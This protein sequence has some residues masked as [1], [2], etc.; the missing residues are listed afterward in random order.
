MSAATKWF[1]VDRAGLA[2][3]ARRRGVPFIVTEPIQNAW[4]EATRIVDVRISPVAN[5]P[6]VDLVVGDDSPDGFRDLR[7][8]YTLFAESYKLDDPEKRGRFNIGEKLLLAVADEARIESTT[9]TVEFGRDGR[10]TLRYRTSAGSILSA[11]LRMTRAELDEALSILHTLIPPDGVATSINGVRLPSRTPI[12]TGFKRTLPTEIRG[13]EGGFRQT[14]RQ[15]TVKIYR[16]LEGE[17]PSLYEMGIPVDAI[18]CPWHVDVGQK[19]PLSVDRSSVRSSY[20]AEIERIAAELMADEMSDDDAREGWVSS[21]LD[22]MED[23]D[24][25]REILRKR[26][27]KAVIFDPSAPQSNKL[28]LDAGYKVIHGSE[29]SRGAWETLRRAEAFEP[30]GRVFDTGQIG[31]SPDGV[32][33]VPETEWTPAMSRAYDYAT[34]FVRHAIGRTLDVVFYDDR[35]LPFS[36]VCGGGRIGINLANG[37]RR[38]IETADQEPLDALLIHET[39]HVRGGSDHLTERFY[40]EC[41]RIGARMRTFEG[42]LGQ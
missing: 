7:D 16:V 8:A 12:A 32:P 35:A 13:E 41:C 17:T 4:D 22:G 28:A 26:F 21:A 10:R 9:G 18:G 15:T 2:E 5:Q 24:A 1:E 29:L 39:A 11:T 14:R 23:D 38:I 31:T 40:R 37:Y 20:L 33:P 19:V 34:A 25:A 6:K 36:G 3:I 27:G 30:A 42:R